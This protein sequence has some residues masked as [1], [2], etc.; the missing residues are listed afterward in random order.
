MPFIYNLTFYN[1]INKNSKFFLRNF[2][3][4]LFNIKLFFVNICFSIIS[5]AVFSNKIGSKSYLNMSSNT[6]TNGFKQDISRTFLCCFN[7]SRVDSRLRCER[8]EEAP[9]GCRPILTQKVVVLLELILKHLNFRNGLNNKKL[10]ICSCGCFVKQPYELFH[11][12]L[13]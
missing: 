10:H 3:F 6:C 4:Y 2:E 1:F 7:S 5:F 11:I 12:G 9:L 13:Y 8:S